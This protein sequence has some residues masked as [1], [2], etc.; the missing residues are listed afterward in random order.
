[1]NISP[2]FIAKIKAQ[3]LARKAEL[4]RLLSGANQQASD[5][6][7]KDVADEAL[8]TSIETLQSSLA[9]SEVEELNQIE[10]ALMRI[11]HG[12]FGLCIDCGEPI[13]EKRLEYSPFS[14]R[15]I[16]CQEELENM[17]YL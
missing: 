11:E 5:A 7:V 1:M 8:T 3:L 13:A 4:Q 12:E 14:A 9:Q 2:S 16:V 17:H 10:S 15:C 6:Q